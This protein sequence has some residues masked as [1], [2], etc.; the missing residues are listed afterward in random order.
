MMQSRVVGENAIQLSLGSS[1]RF[2]LLNRKQRD[3]VIAKLAKA[4]FNW[5]GKA[6]VTMFPLQRVIKLE[7]LDEVG[8]SKE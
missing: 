1:L 2:M 7:A 6:H 4:H 3:G 5:Q 8:T